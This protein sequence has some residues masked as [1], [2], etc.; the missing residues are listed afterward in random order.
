MA[1]DVIMWPRVFEDA[2]RDQRGVK[3]IDEL[4]RRGAP[5]AILYS[6]INGTSYVYPPSALEDGFNA[7]LIQTITA[8]LNR[9]CMST[10]QHIENMEIPFVAVADPGLLPGS[11]L[12]ASGWFTYCT[13]AQLPGLRPMVRPYFVSK[14]LGNTDTIPWSS[15]TSKAIFR[16][17]LSSEARFLLYKVYKSNPALQ[18]VLDVGITKIPAGAPM[19]TNGTQYHIRWCA[20]CPEKWAAAENIPIAPRL[21]MKD[22]QR[23]KYVLSVDGAGCADRLGHLLSGNFVVLRQETQ[24]MEHYYGMLAPYVHYVPVKSDFSDLHEQIKWLQQR[25]DIAQQI[26]KDANQFANVHLSPNGLINAWKDF[27]ATAASLSS[28][29]AAPEAALKYKA[30]SCPI[31]T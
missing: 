27:A 28:P 12:K 21:E 20:S 1:S 15:K 23:F 9:V 10:M 8:N 30:L 22:Q 3:F 5:N 4:K 17:S 25:D 19:F 7:N 29:T 26:V 31:K 14:E 2:P 11:A 24:L 13:R 18:E 6:V 16:G